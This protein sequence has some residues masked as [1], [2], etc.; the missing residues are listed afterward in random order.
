MTRTALAVLLLC[1]VAHAQT[2]ACVPH[3]LSDLTGKSTAAG[4]WAAWR[5]PS[6]LQIVA[7][8][9]DHCTDAV[10]NAAWWVATHGIDTA[11]ANYA[12]AKHGAISFCDPAVRAVWWPDRFLLKQDLA[13][14]DA[15]LAALCPAK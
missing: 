2:V 3:G 6:G 8:A 14:T 13:G 11:G 5:C 1:G 9:T 10:L 7:C 12:M 4:K 15:E